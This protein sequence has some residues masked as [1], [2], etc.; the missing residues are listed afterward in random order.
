MKII[1]ERKIII[2][3]VK[4]P[5][6]KV[7][8]IAFT[9]IFGIG[10]TTALNLC[11]SVGLRPSTLIKYVSTK[12]ISKIRKEINGYI[13]YGPELKRVISSNIKSLITI[14]SYRGSRHRNCLPTRGQRSHRN[15]RTQLR[16]GQKRLKDLTNN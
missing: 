1:K 5:Q 6:N 3:R 2:F 7:C 12:K 15:A 13:I 10:K 9:A 14:S 11:K 4:I 16:L 8:F